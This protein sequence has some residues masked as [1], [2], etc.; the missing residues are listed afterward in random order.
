MT[1]TMGGRLRRRREQQ[2]IALTA[3]SEETKINVSLLEDLERDDLSRWPSGIFR[4]AFIRAYAH[5][6]GLQP[7]TVM[8]EV[9]VLHPDPGDILES[10]PA[11]DPAAADARDAKRP[12]TRFEHLVGSAFR[13]LPALAPKP[14]A[15]VDPPVLRPPPNEI[16][17]AGVA[18]VCTRLAC[19]EDPAD[20][21]ALFDEIATLFHAIGMI[22]WIW[23]ALGAELRPV[24]AHG[25]SDKVLAQLPKVR[26]DANNATAAAFRS[27]QICVVHGSPDASGALAVPLLTPWGCAGVLSIELSDGAERSEPV[28]AIATIVAAQIVKALPVPRAAG[29]E[30]RRA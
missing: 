25:Y 19:A 13:R 23:D 12:P 24:L 2:Q 11:A 6:I 28:R 15:P 10:D 29:I 17:L 21:A 30:R 16:D 18:A 5:A 3:I 20:L 27:S 7:D 9:M 26:R 14:V 1:E 4:R 8:R 22:A